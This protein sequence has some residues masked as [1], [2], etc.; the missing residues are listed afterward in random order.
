MCCLFHPTLFTDSTSII[1]FNSDST[2]YATEFIA[3]FV[4]M[5]LWFAI[6]SLSLNFNKTNFVHFTANSNTK[7]DGNINFEDV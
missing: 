4:K 5:N 3:T 6:N 2:N 7:I 1:F